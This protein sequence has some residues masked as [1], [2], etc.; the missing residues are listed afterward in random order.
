[1]SLKGKWGYIRAQKLETERS[2]SFAVSIA[3]QTKAIRS[4]LRV[5]RTGEYPPS[6]RKSSRSWSKLR[7]AQRGLGYC[8]SL[9][10]KWGYISPQ[11][12]KVSVQK[13]LLCPFQ[14]KP[15]PSGVSL[16]SSGLENIHQIPGNR[17]QVCQNHDARKAV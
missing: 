17:A 6:S 1:M 2:K 5:P 15:R 7:C 12:S 4:W 9:K 11:N 10:L 13:V 16:E 8:M 14:C 3:L